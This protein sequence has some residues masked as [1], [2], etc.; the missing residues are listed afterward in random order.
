MTIYIHYEEHVHMKRLLAS[1]GAISPVLC[2]AAAHAP[3]VSL[4][5]GAGGGAGCFL[6]SAA[7]TVGIFTGDPVL[8]LAGFFATTSFC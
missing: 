6:G 3:A 2:L 7:V 8:A 4:A 5:T 1:I